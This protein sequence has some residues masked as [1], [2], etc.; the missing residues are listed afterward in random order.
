METLVSILVGVTNSY[1]NLTQHFQK[2]Q[3]Q[4]GIKEFIPLADASSGTM[5]KLAQF[6]SESIS[7]QSK[8]LGSGSAGKVKK[9]VIF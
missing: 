1:E 6:V 8:A 2:V 4:M 7:S 5:S 9:D 3:Q